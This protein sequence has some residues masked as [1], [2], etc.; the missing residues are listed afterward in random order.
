[1]LGAWAAML[2]LPVPI[3]ITEQGPEWRWLAWRDSAATWAVAI[4]FAN[5]EVLASP[6]LFTAFFLAT[7]PS[8][9]PMSRRLRAVYG[10]FIGVVAAALQLYVSAATGPLVAVLAGGL[11]SPLLDRFWR[12]TGTLTCGLIGRPT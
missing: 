9:R 1:M 7:S 10:L 2:I 6:L 4:T 11:L 8:I 12:G 5:Y 3:V